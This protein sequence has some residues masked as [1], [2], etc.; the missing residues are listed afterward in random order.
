MFL[1][2]L[3]DVKDFSN[4]KQQ[5]FFFQHHDTIVFLIHTLEPPK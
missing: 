1:R 5:F 4:L 2:I 3:A